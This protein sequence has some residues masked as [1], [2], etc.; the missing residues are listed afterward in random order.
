MIQDSSANVRG[1]ARVGGEQLKQARLDAGLGLQ[2]AAGR[3]RMPVRVVEALEQGR[4]QDIGAP[5]F[6]R[7]Q[8]RS[9][10]KLLGVDLGALLETEVAPVAP[11]DLVSHAHTPR[12][13]R[14]ME[15]AG[16]RAVYVVITAAIAVPVWLAIPRA[17]TRRQA[18]VVRPR[19]RPGASFAISATACGLKLI[20]ATGPP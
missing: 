17:S 4:W 11:V 19:G 15:S 13:Q 3:L 16:R 18:Q 1:D 12:L 7:G 14:L 6:V 9:Y 2:E 10:A 20:T 8:L 5:V